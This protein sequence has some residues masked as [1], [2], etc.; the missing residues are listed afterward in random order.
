[1][2]LAVHQDDAQIL[3][4]EKNV[5]NA[6]SLAKYRAAGAIAQTAL[7]YV[8]Q[9]INDSY[10]LKKTSQLY[11]LQELCLL[12]DSML[13]KLLSTVYTDREQV[14]EKGIAQ[15]VT[16]DVNESVRNFSPEYNSS[17]PLHLAPGD[18]AKISLGAHVD[19]YTALVSHTV[20]IYPPGIEV[21][22]QLKPEGPLLG[23]KADAMVASHFATEAVVALVGLAMTPEKIASVPGLSGNVVSGHFIRQVVDGIARSFGCVV[24]PG[25]KVRRVRR[26]LAGQAEGVV[27]ERDFKGVV[28]NES[29]QESELLKKKADTEIIKFD[30]YKT[31]SSSAHSAIPTDEFFIESGEVY[32]IDIAMCLIKDQEVGLVTLTDDPD[33]KSSVFIRDVAIKHLLKLRAARLLLTTIDKDFSVYPFKLAHACEAFPVDFEN[34]DFTGQLAAIGKEMNVRR[35]GMNEIANRHL[36]TPKPVLL[37]KH[38]PLLAVLKTANPTGR[39]GI[40]AQRL[41]LPGQEIPLPALGISALKLRTMWKHGKYVDSVARESATVILNNVDGVVV[42]LTGGSSIT[43]SWV[44]SEYE[45]SGDVVPTVQALSTLAQDERFGIRVREVQPLELNA[46][47]LHLDETMN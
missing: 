25:S 18:I 23:T 7:K 43:P 1:M 39:H 8:V 41:T 33:I 10:H 13:M 44:H 17:E 30:A 32:H 26:F 6:D 22:Q 36:A 9:L 14:R 42:R 34:G 29:D 31:S 16:I 19:G 45:V 20:V 28:W 4:T 15:P 40:D 47:A 24:V 11:S 3:L 21:D 35:L 2:H 46:S 27:A 5:L 37:V 12:G 38:I